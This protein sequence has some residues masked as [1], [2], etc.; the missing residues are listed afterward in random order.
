M[1]EKKIHQFLMGL[2][3]ER[4]STI[5]SQILAMDPPSMERI[6]NMVSQEENHKTAMASRETRTENMVS[7][8]SH[9]T[10]PGNLQRERLQCKHCGKLGHEEAA[11]YELV[12]YP[13]NW[14]NRGGRSSRNRGRGDRGGGRLNAGR[15]RGRETAYQA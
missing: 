2:D 7:A 14:G 6:F 11:C 12:G 4:Y 9:L 15:G 1:E 10:R 3:D 8:T 5:R 13:A